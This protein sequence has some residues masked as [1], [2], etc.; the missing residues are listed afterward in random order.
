MSRVAIVGAGKLGFPVGCVMASKGHNVSFYDTNV[1][2]LDRWR[3]GQLPQEVWLQEIYDR[4]GRSLQY[5]NVLGQALM[6]AEFIFIAVQTPHAPEQDGSC[7]FN[8]VRAD[9]DLSYVKS[10]IAEVSHYLVANPSAPRTVVIISTMLPGSM[11]R[12]I[13][14][15]FAP[16]A[17]QGNR[18]LYSPSFIAMG[19]VVQDFQ[20]PEFWLIG[21]NDPAN[22][23]AKFYLS[24]AGAPIQ[25]MSYS[26]AEATKV[27]YNTWVTMKITLANL[28]MEIAHHIPG[29]NVADINNALI[30]ADKRITGPSYMRGGMV[31]GGGCHP[32]DNIALSWL[33]EKLGLKYNLFDMMMTIRE[34]QV[35]FLA[36]VIMKNYRNQPVVL[37]SRAFKAGT[38]ITSGSPALLLQAIL[39]ERGVESCFLD[40]KI[41]WTSPRCVVLTTCEIP[42]ETLFMDDIII[43][44]WGIAH[45]Y[46]NVVMVGRQ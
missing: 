32:R 1:T 38:K 15:L 20:H 13:V 33:S 44:P 28:A 37:S 43:D 5:S 11:D 17:T 21:G 8:H 23:L 22:T 45:E 36:D 10:A 19:T 14:P 39:K 6:G 27:L 4:L 41:H 26:S 35:E 24:I 18:L 42:T 7:R 9:F 34:Q 31:D 30:R 46:P 2:T 3:T 12:E 40:E 25:I 16:A 29:C